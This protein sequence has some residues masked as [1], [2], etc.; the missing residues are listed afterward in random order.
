MIGNMNPLVAAQ[1]IDHMDDKYENDPL[2]DNKA[3]EMEM[4]V[5]ESAPPIPMKTCA[6]NVQTAFVLG[7]VL[8]VLSLIGCGNGSNGIIKG[9]IDVIIHCILIFGAHTRNSTAILVWMVLAILSCVGY[10]ILTVLGVVAIAH[11]GAAG[12]GGEAVG[13][14]VVFII[15]MI[16]IIL[17]Q[18]W[19]IIVAKNARKEIEAG[20]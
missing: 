1:F 4:K 9:I 3:V 11:A 10:A 15:F 14:A 8:A 5:L 17:F 18:I 7:I 2:Y 13:V 12:A 19:T 6:T 20:E 16:G